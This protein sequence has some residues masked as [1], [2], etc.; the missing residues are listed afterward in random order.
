MKTFVFRAVCGL[1]GVFLISGSAFA[2]C[3][4]P[5]NA[6]EA[7]NCLPGTSSD[8]WYVQLAGDSSIQG[9]ATDMSVNVGQTI[10][11]KVS[12]TASSYHIEIYRMGYYQGNGARLIT[13][14]T[15]TA[16]LAQGQ[17]SC[18]TDTASLLYDCGN[19]KVSASW[20]VPSS[21]TSGIYFAHL[22]RNDNGGDSIIA[23]VVRNDASTSALLFQT[24]D[25]SWQAYNGYGGHSLY[26]ATSF[27]LTN[28]ASKVSYNRPLAS[29]ELWTQL[30]YAEYPMVRW[31]EANGY[32]VSYFS[33]VDAAR[34]GSLIKNHKIYLS[35]GHDEYVSGPKRANVE[36]AR[37]A[38]VNLAFFSGNEYFWKTRWENSIDGSN[39]PF[40]TLVCYK[41]TLG[42]T[43]NPSATTMV[44]PLDPPTWTGTWRDPSKSPPADGG[45]PENALTGQLF[46]VNGP[47]DDNTALSI[48]VPAADGKMRFWR[49]TAIANQSSGQTWTL[50]TSTLGY[51]WDAEEDNGFRPAGLFDLSTSTHT[52]TSDYLQDYGG[53]YG[54]GVATHHMSLY[55]A[56][57]GSLVFGAGTVQWSWGLDSNHD[58]DVTIPNADVNMQQATVNLFAD[59]GVQPAT[60]QT[61][62]VRASASTDNVP[63]TSAITSP[64]QGATLQPFSVVTIQGTASDVAGVVAG[65]EVST[66]GGATWHRATGRSSWTY[67][68]NVT[69]G[70]VN[71]RSRAVDDSGNLE[72]PSGGISVNI[73]SPSFSSIWNSGAVPTTPDIG[74]DSS[75]ELGVRFKSDASGMITGIR[76][77]KS[78]A[79]TGTHT[80]SL[81]SNS[82]ALLGTAT[83]TSES[84]SGWQIVTFAAP[85][86]ITANTV[87]VASYHT[88]VGHYAADQAY[89]KNSGVDNPP[90]HA[91]Q[92]GVSGSN[93]VYSYGTGSTFPTSSFNSTNYW[94]DVAFKPA[95][96]LNS[97]AVSPANSSVAAGSTQQ[98]A[99]TGTYSDG[100]TADLTNQVTWSSSNTAVAT[101][102]SAGLATAIAGGTSTIA[103][104]SGSVTGSASL[105]VQTG[106]LTITT[107]SLP[108]AFAN[109]SYSIPVSAIGGTA[110]YTWSLVAGSS[111][112]PGLT[113]SS[114]GQITGLATTIGTYSFTVQ[115]KDG[116]APQQSATK[117][118]SIAVGALST[119]T[120]WPASA[121][122][123]VADSGADSGVELG[124]RFRS[125]INSNI[126][127]IR[128]YKS[129][130]NTGTHIGSLWSTTGTLLATAT[131]TNET[132]SGWQQVNFSTPVAITANTVYVASYHTNAGHYAGDHNYFSTA[133]IDNAP[134]HALQDGVGGSD[135]VYAY[136]TTSAFPNSGYLSTNYWVDVVL[137]LPPTLNS[138]TVSPSNSTIGVGNTQ[139][140]TATGLF[141]DGSTQNI[142]SQ[143]TWSSTN[144]SVATIASS[145]LASAVTN[146]SSVITASQG[147]LTGTTTLTTQLLALAINTASLP[148]G[149][150][151]LPYSASLSALGGQPP[152]TWSLA[153]GSAL[154]SGLTLSSG[155]QISGIPLLPGTY[156]F[157]VQ[158]TDA[159]SRV[160]TK[161]LSLSVTTTPSSSFNIWASTAAPTVSDAGADTPV[162]LG[163]RFTA[164]ASGSISGIRFYKSAGN[165]GPHVVNLWNSAGALLAT[166]TSSSETASGWQ[167]VNFSAP[168][169]IT[170]NT[171]YV[172]SYHSNVGHYSADQ[173]YFAVAGVDN[174][175]LHAL[176]NTANTPNGVFVYGATS[177]FPN[178]SFNS[179]NYWVDVAYIVS[180]SL[181]SIAVT[182]VN[183][184]L[185]I[186]GQQQFTATGTFS[187]G[188]SRNISSQATW[189]SSNTTVVTIN[190]SGV[191][192]ALSLGSATVTATA[193]G[194]TG[195]TTLTTQ[196]AGLGIS[197]TSLPGPTTNQPYSAQL[198]ATGGLPPYSWS[199]ASG[200]L[201]AGLVL[202]SSGQ[203]SGTPTTAGTFAFSVT[204]QDSS[205]P[206]HA[207][208]QAL[209]ITVTAAS[210][211]FSSSAV[212]SIVD[213]GADGS[214]ELGVKFKSDVNGSII[215]IRFYKSAANSGPHVVNLWT[216]TGTLLATATSSFETPSGWQQVNFASPI[217]ITASTI[218]VASYHVTAGHYSLNQSF[219]TAAGIDNAP[220]HLLQDGSS[221]S[222]G[223]YAYGSTSVFPASG[224][225]ASNYWVD[226]AFH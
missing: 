50:P 197:T 162:E 51:E 42:P 136:G 70:T 107:A 80:G 195:S 185:A 92:D 115:V 8:Q 101:I 105:T 91:L 10:S 176:Q 109:V 216:S 95:A 17:P 147:S 146:G 33:S 191:A 203:I 114:V 155:G 124:V 27:D 164:D 97:I 9:F 138:I 211:A 98:F 171:A 173:N 193:G 113:L 52:L 192:A 104:L 159:G 143:V 87:Y 116:G 186:G 30:F 77:Y 96:T 174:S 200:S 194:I 89:F 153:S 126:V 158:V 225:N 212:P 85:V 117:Q 6:I 142:T 207:A 3:S 132:A 64:A 152:Y 222:D 1:I 40:R 121:A 82:G 53:L 219:F 83:F 175:P 68:W 88:T 94:V 144:T 135:G 214:V 215:G 18:M 4:Q 103:A 35:V 65:V 12:T 49:N 25:E 63:P 148:G 36:A 20:A 145:G 210:N 188:S 58:S 196:I 150:A 149:T 26:G 110:P 218:Y 38:G 189:S 208:A 56:S 93:G 59:M 76:F 209:S 179:T 165:T 166:A 47:G 163:V 119:L 157:N 67:T 72:T 123:V 156:S 217:A 187:D 180:A 184:S 204:A 31:L 221:G 81:W 45:K 161:Q 224:F 226:V 62:L 127:G 154:P 14:F 34:S 24:S 23:F 140:F 181:N 167:Q 178:S 206:Q 78:T 99:A 39:T 125:D 205:S 198:N 29:I 15:P 74:A 213:A 131:F 13:S 11:F 223:V 21:A 32:D 134:L 141:T 16:S 60:L 54:G 199:I 160:A 201:P 106:P 66:D 190:S 5:A 90:L 183:P 118:L 137:A 168:V 84:A 102:S 172:A 69:S 112:P 133:G 100:S 44:D 111:L 73:A 2:S 120:I 170:A 61:G 122:P 43:S 55:R 177:T 128:F 22:V 169:P 46:R 220:L 75:V 79:N 182:P 71:L 139:Q 19:W 57:S 86:A 151:S 202:S 7:E 129:A 41:E 108:G 48:Q 28:R 130:A 37:N